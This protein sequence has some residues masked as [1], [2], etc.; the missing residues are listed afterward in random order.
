MT[1]LRW[2]NERAVAAFV[3]SQLEELR[4]EVERLSWT[5]PSFVPTEP[6]DLVAMTALVM[7]ENQMAVN[8]PEREQEAVAA[9]LR[10]DLKPLADLIRPLQHPPEFNL[11]DEVNPAVERLSPSTLEIVAQ[12]PRRREKL[13]DRQHEGPVGSALALSCGTTCPQS[14]APCRRRGQGNHR[15]PQATLSAVFSARHRRPC[16]QDSAISLRR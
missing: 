12:V 9:A 14:C 4:S 5:R 13:E 16:R 11:P 8:L 3:A 7:M 1:L 10:G 2:Q 6:P 15:Y